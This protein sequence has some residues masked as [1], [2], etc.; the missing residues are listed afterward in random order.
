MKSVGKNSRP[1]K[2]K[3]FFLTDRVKDNELK[4]IYCPTKE[5][6]VDF[7]TKPL[8]GILFLTYRNAVLGVFQDDIPLYRRQY[9]KY[10]A[11]H[12]EVN[13]T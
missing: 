7:F 10:I 6:V 11:Q 9:E 8:Q 5:M 13:T 3:Y 4:I 1:I 12:N 2:I